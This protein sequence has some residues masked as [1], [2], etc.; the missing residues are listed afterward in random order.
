MSSVFPYEVTCGLLV[1]VYCQKLKDDDGWNSESI[2]KESQRKILIG[3]LKI[4]KRSDCT[5]QAFM[6]I[7]K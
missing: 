6:E 7:I 1:F 2:S 4:I 5:W 3:I